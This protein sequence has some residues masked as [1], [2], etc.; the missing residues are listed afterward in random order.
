MSRWT[1]GSWATPTPSLHEPTLRGLSLRVRYDPP[2]AEVIAWYA[3]GAIQDHWP[4]IR[5][6]VIAEQPV[7]PN[8]VSRIVDYALFLNDEA[9]LAKGLDLISK[10]A[11]SRRPLFAY[12]KRNLGIDRIGALFKLYRNRFP[13]SPRVAKYVASLIAVSHLSRQCSEYLI[14][15]QK[16]LP[17]DTAVAVMTAKSLVAARRQKDA[18]AILEDLQRKGQLRPPDRVLLNRLSKVVRDAET[19]KAQR[20]ARDHARQKNNATAAIRGWYGKDLIRDHWPFVRDHVVSEEAVHPSIVYRITDCALAFNDESVLTKGLKFIG[21]GGAAGRPVFTYAKRHPDSDQIRGLFAIYLNHFPENVRVAKYVASAIAISKFSRESSEFLAALQRVLPDDRVVAKATAKSLSLAGKETDA[22]RIL[23]TLHEQEQSET[24][25]AAVSSD[26]ARQ[27]VG[28]KQTSRLKVAALPKIAFIHIR[29]T[30]G[31]SF[32][33]SVA[34]N[35]PLEQ[36]LLLDE[37]PARIAQTL[38]ALSTLAR[39]PLSLLHGHV[40]FGI[41]RYLTSEFQLVTIL[42]NPIERTI[43]QYFFLKKAQN[44]DAAYYQDHSLDHAIMDPEVGHLF[45][46][47]QTRVLSSDDV[48]IPDKPISQMGENDLHKALENLKRLAVV[49]FTEEF[50]DLLD[51]FSIKFGIRIHNSSPQRVNAARP[52]LK[53]LPT[54]TRRLLARAN[55]LDEAL[56]DA[57]KRMAK[58]R[59]A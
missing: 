18:L 43:S 41:N 44:L 6:R 39:T 26:A 14:V 42:R 21:A 12:A 25:A 17:G 49:G 32:L 22:Y 16:A 57:A 40:G 31:T 2:T 34:R 24:A 11:I 29:K 27:P 35:Y 19:R 10:G 48:H 30:A 3:S 4:L 52:S 51:E 59:R 5:D 36:R 28:R 37:R 23:K 53:E 9:V 15:L 46:N 20:A 55:E 54:G 38:D 56:Y 33:E 47:V 58:D 8:M 1:S 7:D 50:G 45:T 13:E